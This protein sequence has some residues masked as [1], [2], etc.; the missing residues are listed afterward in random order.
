MPTRHDTNLFCDICTDERGINLETLEQTIRLAVE[1]A[2]EGREGRKIGTIRVHEQ[3][4][5]AS[6]KETMQKSK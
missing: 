1:I 6:K 4:T 2:R 3:M 5:V